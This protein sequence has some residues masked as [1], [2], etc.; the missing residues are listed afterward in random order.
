[1]L[2]R[3][4]MIS[5]HLYDSHTLRLATFEPGVNIVA[6]VGSF[7]ESMEQYVETT[8]TLPF[9]DGMKMDDIENTLWELPFFEECVDSEAS[10]DEVLGVLTDEQAE[11]FS[12]LYR[13]W[14]AGVDYATGERVRYD[15]KLYRCVQAHTSQEG[16][17]PSNTPAL[18]VR[19]AAEGDIP[20]WVQP[21]GVQDAYNTGDKVKHNTKTWQST[22]DGNVWE[23]GV[24]GWDE[25]T[26]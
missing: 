7:D 21:T 20:E 3:T 12:K 1:M 19:T 18:W 17:E 24:Y 25:V 4:V 11:N 15:E 23:P 22:I 16:W 8:H 14:A 2:T 9:V 5:G 26:E 10:L 6:V 13:K